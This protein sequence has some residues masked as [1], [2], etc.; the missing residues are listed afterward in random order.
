MLKNK[1]IA[2]VVPAYNEENQIQEVI[3]SMP[4]FVDRIVIVNDKSKD[5]TA[6]IVEEIIKK[7]PKSKFVFSGGQNVK[8]NRYNYADTVVVQMRKD[9]EKYYISHKIANKNP[10]KDRIILINNLENGGVIIRSI[11]R[12]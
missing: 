4:D 7:S 1:T 10:E 2:V 8:R 12:R 3:N 6:S 11:V 5:K 9:E